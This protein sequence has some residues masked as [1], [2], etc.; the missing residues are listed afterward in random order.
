MWSEIKKDIL[1]LSGMDKERQLFGAESHSYSF[2]SLL[3][4]EQISI[5]EDKLDVELPE[6]LKAFYMHLGNGGAGPHYGLVKLENL[7]G[8]KPNKPYPGIEYFRRVAEREGDLSDDGYFEILHEEIQG[9]ISVIPEGCGHEICLATSGENVGKVVYVSCDGHIHESNNS[10]SD[11]YSNWLRDSISAFQKVESLINSEVSME[12]IYQQCVEQLKR[13]DG[14]DL[15]I[16]VMGVKKPEILFGS[17]NHKRYHG[18]TQF[19]WYEKQL[20]SFRKGKSKNTPWWKF[21]K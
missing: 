8:Y 21:W 7:T 9:L 19:P 11:L 3:T 10:L 2:G 1:I 6:E 14:R 4:E 5:V 13:Y 16:S 18:A 17:G 15:A 12:E 20:T